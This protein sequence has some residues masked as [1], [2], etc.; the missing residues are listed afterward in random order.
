MLRLELLNVKAELQSEL[1]KLVLHFTA[2]GMEVHGVHEVACGGCLTI[3]V[4]KRTE[5]LVRA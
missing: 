5:H 3:A 4:A 1:A 2:S